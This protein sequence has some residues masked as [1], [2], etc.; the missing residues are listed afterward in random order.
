MDF[1]IKLTI[2][3]LNSVIEDFTKIEGSLLKVQDEKTRVHLFTQIQEL[4]NHAVALRTHY[5]K[6]MTR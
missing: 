5:Q 1:N 4:K 3:V 2:K 6:V